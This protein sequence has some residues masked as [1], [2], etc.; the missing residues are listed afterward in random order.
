[1]GGLGSAIVEALR[2][3]RHA[4]VEFVGVHDSFGTSAENY[5]LIL[6]KY[7]LTSKAIAERV[8][9]LLKK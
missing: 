4:P 8:R 6:E 7:G 3:E 9:A 5:D 1:V 2:A